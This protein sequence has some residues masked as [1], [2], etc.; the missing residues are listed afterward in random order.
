[1]PKSKNSKISMAK[2][3]FRFSSSNSASSS[4]SSS[5]SA[6]STPSV[7][8]NLSALVVFEFQLITIFTAMAG[9]AKAFPIPFESHGG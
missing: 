2:V 9:G 1:M 7:G 3:F 4:S 5:E 6:E 8:E